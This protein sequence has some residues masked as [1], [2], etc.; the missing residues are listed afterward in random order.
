MPR[1]A[2]DMERTQAFLDANSLTQ[3]ELGEALGVT[4]A[5]VTRKIAGS[6]KWSLDEVQRALAWLAIRL[7]RPVS[8]DEV[9][10]AED[11]VPDGAADVVA[12]D[13]AA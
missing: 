2:S 6:R 5:T 4:R 10:G 7:D 12:P 11:V 9:F 13:P 1:F 3:T 8:F